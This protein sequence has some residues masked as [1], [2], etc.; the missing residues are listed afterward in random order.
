MRARRGN[1]GRAARRLRRARQW[2]PS[3]VGRRRAAWLQ[4]VHAIAT[5][6][7]D[8]TGRLVEH[9]LLDGFGT[10]DVLGCWCRRHHAAEIEAELRACVHRADGDGTSHAELWFASAGPDSRGQSRHLGACRPVRDV[11]RH[12]DCGV[13]LGVDAN[14]VR[15]VPADLDELR[16]IDAKAARVE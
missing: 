14:E 9:P 4:A 7:Q 3:G 6:G 1:C 13:L 8:F 16:L 5:D 12:P 15:A 10:V 2:C 11:H